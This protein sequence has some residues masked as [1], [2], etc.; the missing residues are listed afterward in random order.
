MTSIICVTCERDR[1][2][3]LRLVQSLLKYVPDRR[4][5]IFVVEDNSISLR[6]D[7]QKINNGVLNLE[8]ILSSDIGVA[9]NHQDGWVRQQVIKLLI[10]ARLNCICWILDSKNFL[11]N[12]P[13]GRL[14]FNN[15]GIRDVNDLAAAHYYSRELRIDIV[16]FKLVLPTTPFEMDGKIAKNLID[17]LNGEQW[18]S[19]WFVSR[20]FF[21]EFLLYQIWSLS[22]EHD[23]YAAREH[24]TIEFWGPT[25]MPSTGSLGDYIYKLNDDINKLI[26][27]DSTDWILI[28]RFVRLF[29]TRKT[30]QN[31][32]N[33][34][35]NKNLPIGNY[36]DPLKNMFDYCTV[37]PAI[38]KPKATN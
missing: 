5:I 31:L 24:R 30:L 23:F 25:Y 32:D 38:N 14:G 20:G 8:I 15:K 22:I 3:T 37:F 27:E 9:I 12:W 28:H 4:K 34:L 11:L 18:F 2:D 7:L 6:D 16:G 10:C 33:F 1:S 36:G 17:S 19:N 21:S 13:K 26:I 35:K 29:L